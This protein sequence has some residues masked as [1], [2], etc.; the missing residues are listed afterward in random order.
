MRR[1]VLRFGYIILLAGFLQVGARAQ[2]PARPEFD[3]VSIKSSRP[4]SAPDAAGRTG[5]V[6]IGAQTDPGTVTLTGIRPRDLIARAYSLKTSQ[7]VGPDWLDQEFYDII[8]K[9]AGRVSD[10]EQR[11]MLQ[12]MLASRFGLTAHL[13]TKE[14]PC[15]E[16][17]V[18]KEGLKIRPVVADETGSRN[19]P[20][21]T[22]IRAKA[23][24]M[25]RLSDLLSAKTDRPVLDKTGVS[26]VFDID[27]KWAADSDTD[28]GP[29]IFTAVQEQLGLRLQASKSPIEALVMD[30]IDRPS[31]N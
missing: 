3:V 14:L 29:S 5:A 28:P 7:I 4:T 13:A 20:N 27:L 22:G 19:Y 21:A 26:G 11:L 9:S 16:L 1:V 6:A 23:I 10:S 12:S 18:R 30:H 17:V 31:K 2:A 24:S 25:A 8:A 15:Y